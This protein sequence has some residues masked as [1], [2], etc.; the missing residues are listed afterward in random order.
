LSADAFLHGFTAKL[1]NRQD[2]PANKPL[3][4]AAIPEALKQNIYR[5]KTAYS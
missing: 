1:Q 4:R 5:L 3:R 2:D